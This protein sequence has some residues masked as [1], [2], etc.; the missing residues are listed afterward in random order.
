MRKQEELKRQVV[1]TSK[2]SPETAEKI[3]QASER[4]LKRNYQLYKRLENK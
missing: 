2:N 3:R 1:L 4:I